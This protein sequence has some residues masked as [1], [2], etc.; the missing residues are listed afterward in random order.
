MKANFIICYQT[1]INRCQNWGNFEPL[2]SCD[3]WQIIS[4]P[5]IQV[6]WIRGRARRLYVQTPRL[7]LLDKIALCSFLVAH[8]VQGATSPMALKWPFIF[9]APSCGSSWRPSFA[10]YLTS[11]SR[12]SSLP[13]YPIP[14]AWEC[15]GLGS[16]R[17]GRHS[18]FRLPE[19][20]RFYQLHDPYPPSKHMITEEKG[21]PALSDWVRG[22]NDALSFHN[23]W[24]LLS[25]LKQSSHS[26]LL[27]ITITIIHNPFI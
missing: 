5:Q 17:T 15:Q 6:T 20:V 27:F 9:S 24:L 18:I 21:N 23:G 10:G 3:F 13:H 2:W 16:V 4:Y 7:I 26:S 12:F 25:Y 8:S 11:S 19:I 1:Q 22:L 14:H